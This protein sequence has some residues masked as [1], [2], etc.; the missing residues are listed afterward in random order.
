[1]G[2]W[3]CLTCFPSGV[4][5]SQNFSSKDAIKKKSVVM[6]APLNVFEM[7]EPLIFDVSWMGIPVG[8]GSLQVKEKVKIQGRDAFHVVVIAQTNGFLSQLYP[9]V[10]EM[11]SFIDAQEFYSLEFRKNL[12][13]GQYRADE[14]IRYDHQKRKGF[15]ESLL[16]HTKKEIDI[17]A[18]VHDPLSAFFWFRQQTW[19][20]GRS[21]H[22]VVNSEQ[23]NWDLELN[24]LRTETKE[25]R[26]GRV[27]KTV[28]IEPKTRLRGVIYN[29]GRAWVYFSADSKRRPIWVSL[30]T[31]FGPI[32]G[33]LRT[34]ETLSD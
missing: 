13:E 6:D 21:L 18:K 3:L 11:H 22:T 9:V 15:S 27:I 20:V 1:M 12:K 29:R 26:G 4:L 16:N 2:A 30:K 10:D 24:V 5:A 7:S 33:V 25:L 32:V 17:P 34:Q 31:P 14:V 23:Q 28:V 8:F 19:E